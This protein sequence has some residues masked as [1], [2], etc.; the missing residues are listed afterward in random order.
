MLFRDK[1]APRAG[2]VLIVNA[3]P[4]ITRILE[5]NLAHANF[6]VVLAQNG[7]EALQK[8]RDDKS[9]I[10]ILDQDLIE[11]ENGDFS[12]RIRELA[13]NIPIIL[14]GSRYK[15]HGTTDRLEEIAICYIAKPF[16]PKE[17]VALVQ[18]YLMHKE[19][20][21]NNNP[22][23]ELPK[24][25]QI[26]KESP[27][28]NAKETARVVSLPKKW[29]SSLQDVDSLQLAMDVN[30][31]EA[32]EALKNIQRI[33]A[34]LLVTVPPTIKNSFKKLADE[35]QEMAV[36]CNRSLYLAHDFNRRLEIQQDYSLHREAEHVAT[37]EAILTVCRNITRSIQV[38]LLFD[39]K[40]GRRVAKYALALAKELRISDIEQR[41]L[42]HAA[43]LKDLALAF[44][45]PEVVEQTS[46]VG[47]DKA[48]ALKERLNLLWKAVATIPFFFP[49]CNLLLYRYERY[50][51]T[52]GSF[53]LKGKDIPIGA[54]ILEV[55]DAF[56]ILTSDRSP[57]GSTDPAL[58]IKQIVAE[59]GLSLDPHVVS[60]LMMLLHRNELE[61]LT[62]DNTD[63]ID[64]GVTSG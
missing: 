13:G 38:N 7:A 14:I 56:D 10:V 58:A 40:A 11:A 6:E 29:Q 28:E 20:M 49:A 23:T 8:I 27:V 18:G 24:R 16:E 3:D 21:E 15:K 53:G 47:R 61:F 32:R 34:S 25:G 9:D 44:A 63:E 2:K 30:R 39:L 37:S 48:A 43:L 42:Y 57:R 1:T 54:R 52:G 4:E 51:G 12:R 22:L 41:V 33:V 26:G 59:S 19:R 55:A 60:A 64:L 62:T 5:V 45:H 31:K 35:V 50:D 36:L 46:V 17:V